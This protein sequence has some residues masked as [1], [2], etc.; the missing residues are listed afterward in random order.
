MDL[1]DEEFEEEDSGEP[2][3]VPRHRQREPQVSVRCP[4][5]YGE[6]RDVGA[7]GFD[8]TGLW[9]PV[10]EGAMR[11]AVAAGAQ[12]G[13]DAGGGAAAPAAAEGAMQGAR[14]A[15]PGAPA[16]PDAP[17]GLGTPDPMETAAREYLELL[18]NEYGLHNINDG[19][20]RGGTKGS[21]LGGK[22]GLEWDS[23]DGPNGHQPAASVCDLCI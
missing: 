4:D 2:E 17:Q 3:L 19:L 5:I 8:M 9:L 21:K 1:L 11:K 22:M 16:P 10:E 15:G 7:R 18:G 12:H 14:A 13:G 23:R 20:L 6:W